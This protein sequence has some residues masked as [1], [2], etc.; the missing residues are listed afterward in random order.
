VAYAMRR[1]RRAF[2]IKNTRQQYAYITLCFHTPRA[3]F[4]ATQAPDS[5]NIMQVRQPQN[6]R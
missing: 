4:A 6:T 3:L 1:A 5:Q 2:T